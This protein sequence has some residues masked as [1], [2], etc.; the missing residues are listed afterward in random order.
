[1]QARDC[2]RRI[3]VTDIPTLV[4]HRGWPACYPENSLEGIAA[5]LDA[6][7]CAVEF[8]VQITADG[9]PVV[10]HDDNLRRT[11][12]TD[13]SVLD[14]SCAELQCESVGE[15]A[16][17]GTAFSRT[18]MPTLDETVALLLP[19]K[20]SII[21]VEIKRA[22]IRRFGHERVVP[23][24]LEAVRPLGDNCVVISFDAPAIA[25]AKRAGFRTGWAFE[26]WSD[27]QK[28]IAIEF[29]PEFLFCKIRLLPPA[30]AALWN[31]P[32]TWVAYETGDPALALALGARGIAYVETDSIGE[33]LT[34]PELARR[35]CG[36]DV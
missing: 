19:R 24:V 20:P 27:E 29:A 18:R 22:S 28:S 31:G 35:G 21:F 4:A 34:H 15:P 32:W 25:M 33:L 6:G 10:V 7:A 8:D 1:V 3:F 14:S 9:L 5:A 23:P 12:G 13:R 11:G 30:P 2:P 17:F 36:H 16:R 26:H